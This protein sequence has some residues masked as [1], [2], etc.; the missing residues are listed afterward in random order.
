MKKTVR[1]TFPQGEVTKA[2]VY[3]D[4]TCELVL[5][6]VREI[7]VEEPLVTE[8]EN[9]EVEVTFRPDFLVKVEASSLS[10]TDPFMQY[11]GKSRKEKKLKS[12]LEEVIATGVPDFYRPKNDPSLTEND[13]IRFTAGRK[14]AVGKSYFWWRLASRMVCFERNS[15]LGTKSQ[16]IAFLGVLI[17][18]L[19]ENGMEVSSAWKA[20][21]CDSIELGHYWNSTDAHT[22]LPT[23]THEVCGFCDLANTRKILA[24]DSGDGPFWKVGGY[25]ACNSSRFTLAEI[26]SHLGVSELQDNAVGWI[27]FD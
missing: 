14:P 2:K 6:S 11:E 12:L 27:V 20:V 15:R 22:M 7:E 8:V 25:F 5:E 3:S 10:L 18:K 4:G 19:V 9:V 17:K 13:K 26:E 24:T 16:Y 23:G 1:I 21:C